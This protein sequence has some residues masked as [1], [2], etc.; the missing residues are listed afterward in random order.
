MSRAIVTYN[1]PTRIRFGEGARH[2]L[3][4]AL[5]GAGVK[6][7]L[8]VT[9]RGVIGLAWFGELVKAIEAELPTAVFAEM[10]GNPVVS[11]VDAGVA[12]A[13]AHE[14]DGIIAVGGGAPLDVAK[15]I[16]LMLHHPGHL[17]DYEDDLPGARAVDQPIPWW[18][19]LPTTAGTGSEVGRS[20]VISDDT[21][22]A[23]KI[24]FHP[25]LLAPLVLADPELTYGLPAHITAAT[26][27][28]ALTHLVEAYLARGHHPMADGMALEGVRLVAE[29]L[30]NAVA[31]AGSHPA[32]LEDEE[33]AAYVAARRG[34]LDASLMGAVAFQKGLGVIHSCAHAL[35]TVFDTH[36]G[37]ANAVMLPAGLRYN[38]EAVPERLLSLARVIE[39]SA[40]DGW[41]FID[42]IIDLRARIGIPADLTAIGVHA[43]A[44]DKLVPVAV[45]DACHPNN[46]RPV[47]A[48]DFRAI[49]A[50]ALSEQLD[51]SE[52]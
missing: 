12:A 34:M 16:A 22:H 9:D 18:V 31:F 5:Q 28:D 32:D 39:H 46:P 40:E 23:K 36:H 3:L 24:I 15:A 29:H 35:S 2:E 11:H 27:M 14:A 47:T 50:E 42:W 17:F 37:L 26:G 45:A 38:Y 43:D 44:L 4:S 51:E 7:P 13:R 49:Y 10:G 33:H 30:E 48:D 6:R 20:A 25:R 21:T 41:E 8:F 19:A 1:F 52:G